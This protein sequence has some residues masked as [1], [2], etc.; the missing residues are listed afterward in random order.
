MIICTKTNEK[1]NPIYD[2][3]MEFSFTANLLLSPVTPGAT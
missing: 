2:V 3:S 1:A